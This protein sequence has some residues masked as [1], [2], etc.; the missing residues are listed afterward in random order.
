MLRAVR[1]SPLV[2]PEHRTAREVCRPAHA[3]PPRT[4]RIATLALLGLLSA[5]PPPEFIHPPGAPEIQHF[6]LTPFSA[7][8][9]APL[10][11]RWATRGADRVELAGLGAEPRPVATEGRLALTAE[12]DLELELVARGPGGATS[13]RA[14]FRLASAEPVELVAFTAHPSVVRP[15]EPVRVAWATHHAFRVV[16]SAGG[17][18]VLL[19]DA[20][21][22]GSLVLRPH[23]DTTLRL[24]VEGAGGPLAAER[25]IRVEPVGPLIVAFEAVPP[26]ASL[27]PNTALEWEV[28]LATSISLHERLEDGTAVLVHQ[29][30]WAP[31]RR[32]HEL[33]PRV[34]ARRFELTATL[35]ELEAHEATEAVVLPPPAPRILGFT[36]TPTITGPGGDVFASWSTAGGVAVRLSEDGASRL[37]PA[38]GSLVVPDVYA[39]FTWV[40]EVYDAAGQSARAI[41]SVTVDPTRP[42]LVADAAPRSLEPGRE[43]V[44]SWNSTGH[45][46]EIVPETSVPVFTS[47][48]TE[49]QAAYEP[50]ASQGVWVL[51][52]NERGSTGKHFELRVAPRPLITSFT[53]SA[54]VAREGRPVR[55]AWQTQGADRGELLLPQGHRLPRVEAGQLG[56]AAPASIHEPAL[57]ISN[58]A[59]TTTA[60]LA[61]QVHPRR[62]PTVFEEE[63]NGDEATANTFFGG[64]RGSLE[65]EDVD[66]FVLE[67]DAEERPLGVTAP[68]GG[69]EGAMILEV[70]ETRIERPLRAPVRIE[71]DA[72]PELDPRRTPSLG[73][74]RPPLL[75]ALRPAPG[76][77]RPQTAYR[78]QLGVER[79]TCGDRVVDWSEDCDDGNTLAGDG[80]SPACTLEGLDELEPND[81]PDTATAFD[82]NRTVRGFLRADEADWFVFSV[83]GSEAGPSRILLESPAFGRCDLDAKLELFDH[84]GRLLA[85]A[86]G[87]GLG[88]PILEGPGAVLSAG[89]YR[90][91]VSSGRG[92][93]RPVRGLY[94]VSVYFLR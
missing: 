57:S 59:F 30:A 82:P 77:D 88:C 87:D 1:R 7:S 84:R 42:R 23:R 53:A 4:A 48:R 34:G 74:L 92:A 3:T 5:C 17:G 71:G 60:T 55:F 91:K 67:I 38:A 46:V 12:A 72:C 62:A 33:A 70:W 13:A 9:G 90:L 15:G 49:G 81:T 27:G 14:A 45:R 10:E 73:L 40:L 54:Q 85:Q 68:L 29:E 58:A 21:G 32:R 75:L 41:R 69:C 25:S 78:L 79:R 43:A 56:L 47:T 76:N 37:V 65:G 16:V 8:R 2:A 66:M 52:S 86:E 24:R 64:I 51:A 28:R 93:A 19:E 80:C 18:E 20:P 6:E 89:L 31:G 35:G 26:V 11:L 94:L 63:P 36:V 44:F 61:L 22:D 39:G 83:V 50:P